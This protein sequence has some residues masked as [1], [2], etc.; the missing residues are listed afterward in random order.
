MKLEGQKLD[1]PA[2][3]VVVLPRKDD[4]I[5]FE[6]QAILDYDD[7]DKICPQPE[8]P[9]ILKQ[10]Q[11]V[12]I[13]NVEDPDYK[14]AVRKR[15]GYR[16]DWMVLR[17]LEATKGLTWES[18]DKTDPGTWDCYTKELKQH[19]TIPEVNKILSKVWEVNG[20]DSELLDKARESFL[21]LQQVQQEAQSSL[22]IGQSVTA[23]TEPAKG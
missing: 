21:A 14:E 17:S 4:N 9:K 2:N 8:A 16:I 5:V 3:D 23:S 18:L 6:M 7:F 19:F 11:R 12:A 20:L 13:E 1:G 22:D 15:I 10:G